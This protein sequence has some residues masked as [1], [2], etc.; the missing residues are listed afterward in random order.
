[1]V[2]MMDLI[3]NFNHRENGQLLSDIRK[4]MHFCNSDHDVND[5]EKRFSMRFLVNFIAYKLKIYRF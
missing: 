5:G 2:L 1:M 3:I 4:K